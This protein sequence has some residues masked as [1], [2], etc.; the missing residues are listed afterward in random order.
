MKEHRFE[1]I[2]LDQAI[3][4]RNMGNILQ[5]NQVQDGDKCSLPG[6]C[7]KSKDGYA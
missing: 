7:G 5:Q 3:P 4:V 2:K 6:T 1:I